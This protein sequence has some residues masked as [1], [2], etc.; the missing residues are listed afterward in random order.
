MRG[1][2]RRDPFVFLG[3]TLTTE[4]PGHLDVPT[5]ARRPPRGRGG[6]RDRL[7]P[8]IPVGPR[9]LP[10]R[11]HVLRPVRLPHHQPAPDG[12]QSGGTHRPA[13]VLDPPRPPTA[14]G[15]SA[16]PRGDR[17]L[18][19]VV[20]THRRASRSALRRAVRA[21]LFGQL[22]LHRRQQLVLRPV[23]RAVAPRAHLVARDRG[24]V[25]RGVATRRRGVSVPRTGPPRHAR[26]DRSECRARICRA[27]GR[28][29]RRPHEGVLRHRHSSALSAHRRVARGVPRETR[30]RADLASRLVRRRSRPWRRADRLRDASATANRSCTAADSWSSPSP[31]RR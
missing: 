8:R 6:R 4:R 2:T 16:R 28:A 29:R 7:S 31:S 21:L 10:R 19:G 18:C 23:R 27:H 22:A 20:D 5:R 13:G 11:R 3:G 12:S 26:R 9:R 24:A 1:S 30:E 17:G 15:A 25:L 14:P